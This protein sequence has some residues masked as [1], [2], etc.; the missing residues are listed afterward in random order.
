MID[1][2]SQTEAGGFLPLVLMVAYIQGFTT[3]S[4]LQQHD[5]SLPVNLMSV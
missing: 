4:V 1:G 3:Q 2:R 5:L